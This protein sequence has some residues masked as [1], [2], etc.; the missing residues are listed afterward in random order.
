[1]GTTAAIIVKKDNKYR[2]I[3]NNWDG[4][5]EYLLKMLTEHYSEASKA[6][7]LI[8]L[9]DVSYVKPLIDPPAGLNHTFNKPHP[10][11]TVAYGRDKGESET[12]CR[13]Y[14]TLQEA[15]TKEDREYYYA[16]EDGKWTAHQRRGIF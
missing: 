14:D 7:K 6:N 5:P 4:Y 2:A 10:A 12:E 1:M 3:Y 13:E 9:G 15:M 8:E 11:T 16:W